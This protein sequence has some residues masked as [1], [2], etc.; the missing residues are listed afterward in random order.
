MASDLTTPTV[1]SP[2]PPRSL[3]LPRASTEGSGDEDSVKLRCGCGPLRRGLWSGTNC[4]A[5]PEHLIAGNSPVIAGLLA[6]PCPAAPSAGSAPPKG[7][8]PALPPPPSGLHGGEG[9]RKDQ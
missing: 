9:Q 2:H 4:A 5:A 7:H 3:H 8:R 6:P 1:T